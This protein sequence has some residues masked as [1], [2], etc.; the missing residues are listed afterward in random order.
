MREKREIK[1][2]KSVEARMSQGSIGYQ[3][4]HKK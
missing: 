3:D 1:F 2:V 4:H